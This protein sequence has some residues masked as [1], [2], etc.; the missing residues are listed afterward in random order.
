MELINKTEL[1]TGTRWK[2]SIFNC[3]F[4]CFQLFDTE[5]CTPLHKSALYGHISATKYLLECGVS[6][7][8]ADK[9]GY[10]PLLCALNSLILSSELVQLLLDVGAVLNS[11]SQ[12]VTKLVHQAVSDGDIQRLRLYHLCGYSFYVSHFVLLCRHNELVLVVIS[13]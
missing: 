9:S 11:E 4:S 3:W 10:T 12:L 6:V 8:I 7:H 1:F 13:L 5:G 2:V